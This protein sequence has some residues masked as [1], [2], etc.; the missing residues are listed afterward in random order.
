MKYLSRKARELPSDLSY[1]PN[2]VSLLVRMKNLIFSIILLVYGT[3]G[4]FAQKIYIPMPSKYSYRRDNGFWFYDE[5]AIL[6]VGAFFCG[7]LV[8]ISVIVDHYDKRNNENK[9]RKFSSFFKILG[10][11]LLSVA[12][13]TQIY[14]GITSW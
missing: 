13:I 3:I 5:A 6:I 8:M 2:K 9:Y 7:I 1:I 12:V 11:G 4:L 14:Q 10:Y